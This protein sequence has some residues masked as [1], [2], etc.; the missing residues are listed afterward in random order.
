MDKTI[1]TSVIIVNYNGLHFTRQCIESLYQYHLSNTIEVIVVDNNSSDGS[2]TE[3]PKLFPQTTFILLQENKGFGPANNIG[4]KI[5]NG[6]NLYF[7]N[8]DTLF[9]SES[10]ETLSAILSTQKKYGVVGPKLLNEDNSFQL[11]FGE[12]PSIYSEFSAKHNLI[13]YSLQFKEEMDFELPVEKEWV[14]G[15]ALMIKKE[16]FENIGG[17]D[18]HYFMYFEDIDLCKSVNALGY[19]I[20]YV[21]SVKLIHYGGKSYK[22]N[23]DKIVFEYRRSQLRYYDKYNS[24]F[25]RMFV[26]MYIVL[27]FFPKLFSKTEGKNSLNIVK[28]TYFIHTV[29]R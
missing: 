7:L 14:T 20:L 11:S 24:S 15:A 1:L 5:A 4:A 25:Q 3:L 28:L 18:E 16:I 10:I 22:R 2:Q 8:N 19:T 23:N 27:K 29:D 12:Y 6:T 9:K 21:P 13:D 17:F 26:R